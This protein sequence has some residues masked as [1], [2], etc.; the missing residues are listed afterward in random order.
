MTRKNKND[1]P[2]V[3]R[4]QVEPYRIGMLGDLPGPCNDFFREGLNLAFTEY[5]EKGIGDRPIE[6]VEREYV[7]HPWR[8]GHPNI[9]AYVDLIE[10]ENVI[11]FAGPMTTDNCLSLLPVLDDYRVPSIGISGTQQYVGDYAFLTPNGGMADEPAV[12]AGWIV[13]QGYQS[14]AF[15]REDPSQIGRE[16]AHYFHYEADEHGFDIVMEQAISPIAG[17]DEI[18]VALEKL[19]KLDADCLVYFG[20]GALSG[21]LTSGLARI[22]WNPPRIMGT[23]FVGASFGAD[24]LAMYDGWV[25]LD[26]FHEEN[27]VHNHL[28]SLYEEKNGSCLTFQNSVFTCAYDICRAYALAIARM[29]IA[30]GEALRDALETVTRL[31]AATGAPGTVV[32]FSP[33]DHRGFKGANYLIIRESKGGENKLVGCAPVAI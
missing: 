11:G 7:A 23:A 3:E 28:L 2:A 22:G 14:I 5:V 17:E 33:R 19:R 29:R 27:E 25:G 30:T 15:I 16:Y 10:N 13:E 6:L 21:Q 9:E 12:I 31:P 24:R 20:F 32:S 26:Q 1:A 4:H 18:V 8:A